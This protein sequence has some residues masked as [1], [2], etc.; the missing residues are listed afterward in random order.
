MWERRK[1]SFVTLLALASCWLA[2]GPV[3]AAQS[4]IPGTGTVTGT[5]TAGKPFTA[6]H[7]YLRS[8][9]KPVTFM[10]YTSGGKYQAIN[11]FPG[12]YEVTVA[13]RG[14]S[15]EPQK[16]TVTSGATTNADFVLKDADPAPKPGINGP[17]TVVGYPGRATITDKDVEFHTDYAA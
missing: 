14:F 2:C 11:L 6:A 3:R 8:T 16:I 5:V 7:V 12:E 4:T 15:S 9:D 1:L 17:S 13:R 10:V